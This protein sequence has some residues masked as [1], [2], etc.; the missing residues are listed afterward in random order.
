MEELTKDRG[1]SDGHE[2]RGNPDN[3]RIGSM[4]EIPREHARYDKSNTG[5]QAR[6]AAFF[7]HQLVRRLADDFQGNTALFPF[8]CCR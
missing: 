6:S 7:E 2:L 4:E 5:N 3:N 8:V 1:N